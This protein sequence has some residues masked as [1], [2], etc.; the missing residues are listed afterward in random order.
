MADLRAAGFDNVSVDLIAGLP[1]ETAESLRA[2]RGRAIELLPQHVSLYLLE[3][4][5]AGK[6]SPLAAAVRAGRVRTAS[7]DELADW[8]E[9]S[10]DELAA[11]G[12]EPYEISNFAR[13]GRRSRHNLK[14]WRCEPFLACGVGAHWQDETRV[15]RFDV[16]GFEAYLREV[17]ARGEAEADESRGGAPSDVAA[18]RVMLGLRLREGIDLGAIAREHPDA[19]ARFE[20]V[21]AEHV[22]NAL[23]V[24][25]GDRFRLTRRGALL[26]NEVFA[27]VLAA[28]TTARTP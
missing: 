11:A 19:R 25:E 15:R 10:C 21:L 17:E 6:A 2:S 16:T 5:E 4:D 18:E 7:D 23:V 20:P 13:E 26:S 8:Y 27:D 22:A 3:L 1:H 24:R 28:E 14:Y 9:E 12:L